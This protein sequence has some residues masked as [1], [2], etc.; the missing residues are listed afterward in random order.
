HV[1][2][3]LRVPAVWAW[4]KRRATQRRL[5]HH[6][7]V[8]TLTT[9]VHP[10]PKRVGRELSPPEVDVDDLSNRIDSMRASDLAVDLL[11]SGRRCSSRGPRRFTPAVDTS[12]SSRGSTRRSSGPRLNARIRGRMPAAPRSVSSTRF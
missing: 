4:L 3:S 12:A 11:L 8:F 5:G 10:L 7:P 6:S 9:Y 1:R 2:P